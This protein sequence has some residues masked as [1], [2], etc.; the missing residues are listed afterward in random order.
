E[1]RHNRIAEMTVS[2]LLE[3]QGLHGIDDKACE[4]SRI[5]YALLLIKIPRANLPRH[6][7]ALQ[8]MG[9]PAYGTLCRN[10]ACVQNGTQAI[11]LLLIAQISRIDNLII[12][13]REHTVTTLA[14]RIVP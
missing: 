11:Q 7:T 2:L 10:E 1:E 5:K 4:A 12:L 14:H 13:A 8:T 6:Q 3:R 9:E